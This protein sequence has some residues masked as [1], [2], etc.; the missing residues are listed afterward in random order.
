MTWASPGTVGAPAAETT[1]AH[2]TVGG[3]VAGG[4][5][6]LPAVGTIPVVP[7]IT[8]RTSQTTVGR[9]HRSTL[10]IPPGDTTRDGAGREARTRRLVEERRRLIAR[11][12]AEA[13]PVTRRRLRRKADAVTARLVEEHMALVNRFASRCCTRDRDLCLSAAL[14]GLMVAIDSWDPDR[15]PFGPWAIRLVRRARHQHLRTDRHPGVGRT[16]YEWRPLILDVVD[17]LVARGRT[18]TDREVAE[19]VGVPETVVARVRH[20][21]RTVPV[22]PAG[23]GTG[24]GDPDDRGQ[25]IPDTDGTVDDRLIHRERTDR[26]RDAIGRLTDPREREVLV[27]HWGLDGDRRWPLAEIAR[28]WGV[29]TNMAW[30]VHQRA[31]GRLR[32]PG[33]LG[34][35]R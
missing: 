34:D 1:P 32:D 27:L 29:S 30:K 9:T 7:E 5:V 18:P 10:R 22:G 31:L 15:G 25:D 19:I 17:E 23:D 12:G 11:A 8:T 4:V 33:M 6:S 21:A 20:P 13:D 24:N 26:V 35:L 3:C 2:R 14:E 16:E 28:R